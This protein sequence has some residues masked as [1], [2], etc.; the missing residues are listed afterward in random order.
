MSFFIVEFT[1]ILITLKKAK[2]HSQRK[3]KW[4]NNQ[5][6]TK[7]RKIKI[8]SLPLLPLFEETKITSLLRNQ[9][10][11]IHNLCVNKI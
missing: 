9:K 5:F 1:L 3:N 4:K 8:I 11:S 6:L 7:L 10:T 2:E